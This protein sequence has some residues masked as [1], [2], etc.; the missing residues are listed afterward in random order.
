MLFDPL[1]RFGRPPLI[2]V[3][4]SIR[5]ESLEELTNAHLGL[6]WAD[7]RSDFPGVEIHPPLQLGIEQFGVPSPAPFEI[8]VE[9]EPP[10]LRYWFL[11]DPRS[12]LVQV[13]ADAFAHNWRR[14]SGSP[15]YPHYDRIRSSFLAHLGRFRAFLKRERLRDIAPIQCEVTYVNHILAGEGW[16]KPSDLGEVTTLWAPGQSESF[17]PDAEDVRLGAR[18]VMA[19]GAGNPLGRLYVNLEPG[20]RQ[21]PLLVLR[22][23]A[24]GRPDGQGMEGA[25][26]F[27]DRGHEWIVRG[28]ASLTTPRM[29]AIWERVQ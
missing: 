6:L 13:Q 17:L 9:T 22:L 10:K 26:R 20:Y 1:P 7:F 4:L 11:N 8:T 19:D 3:A 5:F 15:D 27:L 29:H 24:R 28:F 18:Y 16:E 25:L 14:T 2:E 21:K 12:E 23:T